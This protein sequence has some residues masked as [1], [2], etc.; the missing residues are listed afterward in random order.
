MNT[1][2]PSFEDVMS[3]LNVLIDN[4]K[5]TTDE[6]ERRALLRQFRALLGTVDTMNNDDDLLR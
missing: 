5:Q 6:A 1:S 4:L 3:Q 2:Q